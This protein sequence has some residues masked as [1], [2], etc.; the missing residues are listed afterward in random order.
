LD[1]K[2][3]SR[4]A[5]RLSYRPA[6]KRQGRF[7]VALAAPEARATVGAVAGEVAREPKRGGPAGVVG[8]LWIG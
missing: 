4:E 2:A 7:D 5:K 8:R 6:A 3:S 1:D